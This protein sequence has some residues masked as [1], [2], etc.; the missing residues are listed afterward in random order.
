MKKK[1]SILF[2]IVI[3]LIICFV[4]PLM[5]QNLKINVTVNTLVEDKILHT[6]YQSLENSALYISNILQTQFDTAD[7]Y[8]TD[9]NV[10]E[11]VT[12][13]H[14]ADEQEK[15]Q[16]QNKLVAKLIKGNNIERYKYPYYFML[17]DYH[18]NMMT[19]Y[20]YTPHANYDEVY[21]EITSCDWF[22]GL[23]ASYTERTAMFTGRDFLNSHGTSK[24][25]VAT[26]IIYNDNIGV[27][28]IAIDENFII[29]QF[30][31]ALPEGRSFIVDHQGDCL[32]RFSNEP[33]EY[34]KEMYLLLQ[35][36]ND[37][38]NQILTTEDEKYN[39]LG[40]PVVIKGYPDTWSIISIVPIQILKEEVYKIRAMNNVVLALY[41]IAIIWVFFLLY[42]NIVKPIRML[43]SL[44][45]EVQDGNLNVHVDGLPSNELGELGNGFNVMTQNLSRYFA[46]LKKNE[47]EKRVTEVRLLQSQIKPHFVR[48]VLNTIR[49]MAE[50]NGMSGIGRSVMS[51]S[52]LL[53]YNFQNSEMVSTLGA[54]MDYVKTYIYLQ[55][56]RFQNKFKD[57][58]EIDETLLDQPILKLS[59]QP[60]VENA[61]YH[62][63]MKKEGLGLIRIVVVRENG[64][65]VVT[66]CD[67]GVGIAPET[68]PVILEPPQ[69]EEDIYRNTE[70]TENIA[71]WNI[72]QRMKRRYGKEYE[73]KIFSKIGEGTRVVLK[74]PLEERNND[75]DTDY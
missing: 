39:V 47:E 53:E 2:Q 55:K 62:G 45:R 75:K 48:N 36:A 10:I 46:D 26:N 50:I 28:I 25:Y 44:V 70:N 21:E 66:I 12:K 74:V 58:Y 14:T 29:S 54:E 6:A 37:Q 57:E 72:N 68:I 11:A 22:P 7:Y 41:V 17:L 5:Y 40:S 31:D 51:L 56:V 42:K 59:F 27:L 43:S 19:N 4:I 24:F 73:L 60:I 34:D 18:G 69:K 38:E 63:L 8:K 52:N 3:I 20:T 23:Q 1:K 35:D 71:L 30:Y 49:W 67:D 15:F 16:M 9:E 61:I 32:I 13:M 65:M 64:D 33:V